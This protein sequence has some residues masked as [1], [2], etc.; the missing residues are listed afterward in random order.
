[1]NEAGLALAVSGGARPGAC[2]AHAALLGRDC[3]ERFEGVESA[4]AWCLGRPAAPGAAIL[5]ADSRGELGGVELSASARQV[6]RPEGGL[7]V[8]GSARAARVAKELTG[9]PRVLS[10][11]ETAVASAVGQP[12]PRVD[13][14]A[15]TLRAAG[16]EEAPGERL[17]RDWPRPVAGE[18]GGGEGP[19]RSAR[20]EGCSA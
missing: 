8:L 6:R 17:S 18:R 5:F 14:A 4:L 10:D 9:V 7:L 2:R 11:L 3:L 19:T 12:I 1:V 16:S 13:L 20:P 15:R